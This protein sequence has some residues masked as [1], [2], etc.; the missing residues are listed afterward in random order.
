MFTSSKKV[1]S[2][3]RKSAEK[4]VGGL[5]G[6]WRQGERIGMLTLTL[7]AQKKSTRSDELF[8]SYASLANLQA[9]DNMTC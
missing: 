3:D 2:I 9:L 7:P 8:I 5:A 1:C 6:P 4:Y